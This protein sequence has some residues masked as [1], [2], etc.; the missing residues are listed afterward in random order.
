M[1]K[2]RLDRL[3][4]QMKAKQTKKEYYASPK[5][6]GSADSLLEKKYKLKE[7]AAVFGCSLETV[8]IRF[9]NESGIVYIGNSPNGHRRA[10]VI[11]ESVLIRVYQQQ[12]N[13]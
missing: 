3:C 13:A 2:E 6:L 4:A 1:K 10:F 11:P 12:T 5:P 7:A 8:R 9:K